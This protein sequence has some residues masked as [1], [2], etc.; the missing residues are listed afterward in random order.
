MVVDRLHEDRL[1]RC[2]RLPPSMYGSSWCALGDPLYPGRAAV[3]CGAAHPRW[4]AVAGGEN[5]N[6]RSLTL[7]PHRRGEESRAGGIEGAGG[8]EGRYPW[9]RTS[10]TLGEDR[11]PQRRTARTEVSMSH[12][13]HFQPVLGVRSAST[14]EVDG[15]YFRDLDGDGQLAPYEDW[16]LP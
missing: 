4:Q 3:G 5:E 11:L 2:H 12:P 14:I 7:S 13:D 10:R 1:G 16:R 15:L 6:A 9:I 8:T